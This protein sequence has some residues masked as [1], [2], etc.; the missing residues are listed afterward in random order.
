MITKRRFLL[1]RVLR[2]YD[3]RFLCLEQTDEKGDKEGLYFF[4]DELDDLI[5]AIHDFKKK[6]EMRELRFKCI[7]RK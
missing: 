7:I 6:R 2:M 5:D 1:L 3:S 4:D